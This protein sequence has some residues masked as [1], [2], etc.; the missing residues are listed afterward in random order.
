MEAVHRYE[1]TVNQ[2]MGDGI[3]ALFRAPLVQE[4]HAVRACY[5]ALR[6]QESVKKYAEQVRRAD[7]AV[8]S[9]K[10]T[11]IS[12]T[13]SK[14]AQSHIRLRT[15]TH[16]IIASSSSTTAGISRSS[17]IPPARTTAV[18]RAPVLPPDLT[19]SSI[20]PRPRTERRRTASTPRG[21]ISWSIST[22]LR[23]ARGRRS[24]PTVQRRSVEHRP[25]SPATSASRPPLRSIRASPPRLAST[26]DLWVMNCPSPRN[27]R[28]S[29]LRNECPGADAA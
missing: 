15:Y 22:V 19:A 11:T 21:S 10:L 5:A 1:G 2:V 8:V 12:P 6:M 23:K 4:N 14:S 24:S 29:S 26:S 20:S 17:A 3:M 9:P 28:G 25:A 27:S 16:S 13:R 7:A 18:R